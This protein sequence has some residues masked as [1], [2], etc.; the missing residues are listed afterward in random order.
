[1]AETSVVEVGMSDY[2]DCEEASESV[3]QGSDD[4]EITILT[5]AT[6]VREGVS[7]ASEDVEIT[8]N[9][10]TV[11][12]LAGIESDGLDEM[13]GTLIVHISPNVNQIVTK[14]EL[15]QYR[16]RYFIQLRSRLQWVSNNHEEPCFLF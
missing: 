4:M 8:T 3:T 15:I 12:A 1:M 2:L 9:E 11:K 6:T 7:Q 13:D 16:R 14:F 10:T 5:N